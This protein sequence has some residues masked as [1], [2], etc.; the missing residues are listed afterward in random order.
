MTTPIRVAVHG[1]GNIGR[2]AVQCIETAPDMQCIG[3]IR[4]PASLGTKQH[5]L[6]S[7]P[8]FP[9]LDELVK[10]HGKP[11]VVIIC[12][13]SR[14]V[15]ADPARYLAPGLTTVHSSDTHDQIPDPVAKPAP[16]AAAAPRFPIPAPCWAPA[17]DSVLRR[18]V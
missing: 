17:P 4:S 15:P 5:D 16:P 2:Q 1:L 18:L 10:A 13:P 7:V 9:G 6:R 3:V 8:D 14:N 12:G 11:D